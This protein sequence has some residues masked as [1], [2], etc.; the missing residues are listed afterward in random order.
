M[1]IY[2]FLLFKKSHLF[3]LFDKRFILFFLVFGF[4]GT[5]LMPNISM[6]GHVGG[7]AGGLLISPFVVKRFSTIGSDSEIETWRING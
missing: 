4:A 2:I 5:I 1:G 3:T 7:F 6:T